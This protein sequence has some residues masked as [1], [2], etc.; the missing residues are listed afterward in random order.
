[1]TK[2]MRAVLAVLALVPAALLF[3]ILALELGGGK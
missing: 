1:M 2:G 3:A